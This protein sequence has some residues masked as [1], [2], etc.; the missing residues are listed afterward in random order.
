MVLQYLLDN[1][2]GA[3]TFINQTRRTSLHIICQNKNVTLGM[4]QLL[5]DAAPD[6]VRH[7]DNQG[8]LPLHVLCL[9]H[10]L[11]DGAAIDIL[12]LL[13]ERCPESARHDIP[14]DRIVL[15]RTH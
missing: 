4:V 3:G 1:F 7:G 10:N 8:G 9:N 5:I 15:P 6:S 2:P 14:P 13:L 11:D 12:K